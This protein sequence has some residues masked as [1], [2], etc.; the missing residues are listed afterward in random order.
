MERG[1]ASLLVEALDR[2]PGTKPMEFARLNLRELSQRGYDVPDLSRE[3]PKLGHSPA[4]QS[5]SDFFSKL[6]SFLQ[7]LQSVQR[8]VSLVRHARS[9]ERKVEG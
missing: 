1:V 8:Q 2:Y 3:Q 5:F 6:F 9:Q 7:P 4:L